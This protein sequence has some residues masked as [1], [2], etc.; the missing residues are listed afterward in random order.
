VEFTLL[1]VA[2]ELGFLKALEGAS[3]TSNVISEVLVVIQGVIEVVLKV[4]VEQ[5]GKYLVHVAL[6]TGWSICK[7]KSHYAELEGA[8][9]SHEGAIISPVTDYSI[10]IQRQP[11][12]PIHSDPL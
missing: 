6:E 11:M 5:Q 2:E 9:W 12:N 1:W 8:K 4:L 7:S 3:D 10:T